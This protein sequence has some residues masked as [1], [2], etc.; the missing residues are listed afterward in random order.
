MATYKGFFIVLCSMMFAS[1]AL[2]I[3]FGTLYG[4]SSKDYVSDDA[5]VVGCVLNSNVC[6]TGLCYSMVLN[7][8]YKGCN[9][10]L[11]KILK[12]SSGSCENVKTA[13]VYF[14]NKN[15]CNTLSLSPII[16][17]QAFFGVMITFATITGII[18][19]VVTATGMAMA[20]EG[21]DCSSSC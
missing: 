8:T 13:T 9:K 19:L 5:P 17:D 21:R 2:V 16:H 6:D 12:T 15:M 14:Y 3:V 4:L 10:T 1:S 20:R 18:L 7:I 11:T